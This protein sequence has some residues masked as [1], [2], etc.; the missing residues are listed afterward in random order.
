MTETIKENR[1]QTSQQHSL[2]GSIALHLIPGLLTALTAYGLGTWFH[3]RGLPVMLAFYAATLLVL[4]PLLIGIPLVIEKKRTGRIN[5]REILRFRESLPTWQTVLI[6]LGIV[7]WSGLV[8]L[9]AAS[10]L[11]EPL[12]EAVF[13]RLPAWYDLGYYLTEGAYSRE[14]VVATWA[15][16]ILFA[17]FL[18][19]VLE[20]L[21][22][23]GYLL[24]RLPLPGIW[25]PLAGVL[26]FALYHFWSP[27]L[28]L[29]RIV[30][31]LPLVLAVW[32]K[33]NLWIGVYS[34]ILVNLLGDTLSA[35]P[36]VFP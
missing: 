2:G 15:L 13:T 17:T 18:G 14:A 36:L 25:A 4:F 35:I 30:A 9:I 22:F 21:Y 7:L 12:R 32:W 26:L 31:L 3:S 34:H 8:F 27:W 6:V 33:K 20:E 24:P 28:V 16:G 23:R 10:P 29:V 19:P 5:L 1:S 11:A